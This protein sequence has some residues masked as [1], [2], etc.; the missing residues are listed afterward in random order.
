M[1][2]AWEPDDEDRAFMAVYGRW[3]P[4][5][6]AQTAALMEGFPEPWW[7]VGGR[8]IEAFTGVRRA[9]EDTDLVVF[10][11]AVAA[12]RRQLS[13]FHLWSNSGG[14]FRVIDD[15]NPEPLDPLSQIWVRRDADSPWLLD[16]PLNPERDGRWVSK[17]DPSIHDELDEV[18]WVAPDGIRYLNPELVLH[19]KSTQMRAKDEVDFGNALPLLSPGQRTWLHDA[20]ARADTD[21]PWLARLG[22]ARPSRASQAEP[23]S[24][25]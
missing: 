16:I 10:N 14:T 17:R 5:G 9:H 7:I 19:Y 20:I 11:T 4:L 25:G 1:T 2:L 15:R 22:W 13:A 3:E 21:H 12:L 6:P 8:A 18:T 24:A 23:S